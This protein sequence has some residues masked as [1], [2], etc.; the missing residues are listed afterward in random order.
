MCVCMSVGLIEASLHVTEC[1][2]CFL[3]K[4]FFFVACFDAVV[5]H[6]LLVY[7]AEDRSVQRQVILHLVMPLLREIQRRNS[8]LQVEIATLEQTA[9][10]QQ[11]L[12][13]SQEA[14]KTKYDGIVI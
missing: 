9:Q 8:G 7:I 14:D 6:V 13:Q 11:D 5:V 3:R 10:I 12:P 1:F 2:K 4:T